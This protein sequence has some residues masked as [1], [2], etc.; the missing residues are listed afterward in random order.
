MCQIRLDK[1]RPWSTW[2]NS[3][4]ICPDKICL[5]FLLIK[6]VPESS[7]IQNIFIWNTV[8]YLFLQPHLYYCLIVQTLY[9][10]LRGKRIKRLSNIYPGNEENY[11]ILLV[12]EAQTSYLKM[13]THRVG[14]LKIVFEQK[15][16]WSFIDFFCFL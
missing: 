10:I 5:R 16:L 12:R 1:I 2:H 8:F 6:F 14:N 13:K 7:F 9:S 15:F 11:I 4:Q 3:S